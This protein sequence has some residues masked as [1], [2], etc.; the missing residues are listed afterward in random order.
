LRHHV[1]CANMIDATHTT[2]SSITYRNATTGPTHGHWL[3]GNVQKFGAD[4]TC[5]PIDMLADG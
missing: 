1:H 2:G 3:F 5:R 4:R